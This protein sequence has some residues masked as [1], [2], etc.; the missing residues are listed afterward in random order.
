MKQY[1]YIILRVLSR[2]AKISWT[3]A[4]DLMHLIL[5][6]IQM[7][8]YNNIIQMLSKFT[9]KNTFAPV[10]KQPDHQMRVKYTLN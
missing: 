1:Y 4:Y 9:L 5:H 8:V 6:G 2:M 10:F 3:R 7:E